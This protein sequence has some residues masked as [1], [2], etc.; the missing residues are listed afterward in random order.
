M[1][2]H[3]APGFGQ[4]A[5]ANQRRGSGVAQAQDPW[6]DGTTHLVM[7]P[8]QFMQRPAALVSSFV[9]RVMILCN[10]VCIA[11]LVGAGTSTKTG[12][13]SASHR[14]LID[15][16][17]ML[18]EGGFWDDR[19]KSLRAVAGAFP[20]PLEGTATELAIRERRVDHYADVLAAPDAPEPLR[21]IAEVTGNY[22][23][24]FAPLLWGGTRCWLDPGIPGPAGSIHGQRALAPQDLRRPSRHRDPER[25]PVP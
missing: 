3:H 17:G 8:L 6:R 24:A 19:I 11:S 15:E 22:S 14:Y 5:R 2:L 13:P 4:P 20:R 7:S 1:P 25:T 18:Q 12:S 23:I 21:G 16:A 10:T 9:I